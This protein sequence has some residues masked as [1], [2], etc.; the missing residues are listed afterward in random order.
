MKEI[1]GLLEFTRPTTFR[2]YS[3][4]LILEFFS[5]RWRNYAWRLHKV[6]N[7]QPWMPSQPF[8][9]WNA[10]CLIKNLFG[11]HQFR[12]LFSALF[13]FSIFAVFGTNSAFSALRITRDG[14]VTGFSTKCRLTMYFFKNCVFPFRH[15]VCVFLGTKFY[16]I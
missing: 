16:N 14:T 4:K 11:C 8:L 6:K 5:L 10:W 13:H 3:L 2:L 1:S 7:L 12:H 15:F 9:F